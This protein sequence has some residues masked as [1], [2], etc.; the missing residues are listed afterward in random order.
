MSLA[1]R[2]GEGKGI[3]RTADGSPCPASDRSWGPGPARTVRGVDG[4]ASAVAMRA[5][6]GGV[7]R[8]RLIASHGP[9]AQGHDLVAITR[10]E[11]GVLPL[12]RQGMVLGRSEEHTSELQSL[13]RTSSAV[14]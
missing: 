11:H 14:F 5:V 1:R 2:A 3:S 13:M 4:R 6:H 12:R 9:V 8:F 10:D 7:G